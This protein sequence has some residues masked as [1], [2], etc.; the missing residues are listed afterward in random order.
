MDSPSQKEFQS[1]IYTQ[2]EDIILMYQLLKDTRE[3][4]SLNRLEYWI[5]GG[6]LLGAVRHG[7]IIPWDDDLDVFIRKTDSNIFLSMKDQLKILGY[8]IVEWWYGGYR[9]YCDNG[10]EIPGNCKFPFLDVFF[11]EIDDKGRI[12]F[13]SQRA[14]DKWRHCCSIT[15]DETFPLKSYRFGSFEVLG[16]K[17]S[18][19]WLNKTYGN[20]WCEEAFQEKDHQTGIERPKNTQS[21]VDRSPALPLGPLQNRVH[22]LLIRQLTRRSV[23]L[24]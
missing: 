5:H 3:L 24:S 16:P 17:N 14:M 23:D 6:T 18:V 20:D 10:K 9:I 1:L 12:L 7:G 4:F 21:L 22:E 2:G 8:S 15:V 19:A 11:A 13:S